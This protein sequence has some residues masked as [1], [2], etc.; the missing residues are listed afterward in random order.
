M[1]PKYLVSYW[2]N[3]KK[4]QQWLLTLTHI[5]LPMSEIQKNFIGK[6]TSNSVYN[7]NV[8]ISWHIFKCWDISSRILFVLVVQFSKLCNT[9]SYMNGTDVFAMW[10][11][12]FRYQRTCRR[13]IENK[14]EFKV[15]NTFFCRIYLTSISPLV[16]LRQT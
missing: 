3:I 6:Y 11:L 4:L 9:N 5:C 13:I 14:I 15:C 8:G 10:I 1:T 12:L 7:N 2:I 16:L